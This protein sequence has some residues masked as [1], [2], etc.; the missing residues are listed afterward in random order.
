VH[1]DTKYGTRHFNLMMTVTLNGPTASE[2]NI[3]FRLTEYSSAMEC[4]DTRA[5]L[6][7]RLKQLNNRGEDFYPRTHTI[8]RHDASKGKVT[9]SEQ[10]G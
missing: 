8:T 5:F 4:Y 1:S 2:A 7:G 6:K 9:H 3:K 10:L